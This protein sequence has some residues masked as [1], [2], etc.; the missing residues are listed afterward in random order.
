MSNNIPTLKL[1]VVGDVDT[2]KTCFVTRYVND[3]FDGGSGTA[4]DILC[5]HIYIHKRKT[6]LQLWI[7]D[8][9]QTDNNF[10]GLAPTYYAGTSGVFI[11]VDVTNEKSMKNVTSWKNDIDSKV[12]LF[13][14]FCT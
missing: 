9:T 6:R 3:K 12:C 4:T 10:I 14:C 8:T 7:M 13:V 5:K 11:M 2:G 1:L